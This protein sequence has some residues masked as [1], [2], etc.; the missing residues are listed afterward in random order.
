MVYRW[1]RT[2]QLGFKS[3]LL[4][5]LIENAVKYGMQTSALPLA[6]EVKAQSEGGVLNLEVSNTGSWVRH[7][8]NGHNPI[9]NGA[10]VGLENVRQRLRQAFAQ[11]QTFDV[12]E[13]DGRVY[14]VVTITRH[15]K[16]AGATGGG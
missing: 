6:I 3:L 2:W 9:R 15:G 13:R 8:E 1:V 5:P 11:N 4:H 7:G 16:T 14:A 10:G 12:F